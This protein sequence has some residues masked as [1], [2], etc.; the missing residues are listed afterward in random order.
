MRDILD[1]ER[2][3]E[4]VAPAST[5]VPSA[6][7]TSA[8][9]AHAVTSTILLSRAPVVGSP[10]RVGEKPWVRR[11]LTRGGADPIQGEGVRIRFAGVV[12]SPSSTVVAR[13]WN[14]LWPPRLLGL[15]RY[16]RHAVTTD[17]LLVSL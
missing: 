11:L 9:V 2:T 7:P 4:K 5:M 15:R 1:D 16:R 3:E 8:H 17:G 14:G 10:S 12:V 6:V 13:T